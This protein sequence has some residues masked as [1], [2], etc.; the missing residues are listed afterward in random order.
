M[1]TRLKQSRMFS[2]LWPFTP[3]PAPPGL[4]MF[5]SPPPN[6]PVLVTGNSR[7]TLRKLEHWLAPMGARVLA[8]DTGGNDIYSALAAGALTINKIATALESLPMGSAPTSPEQ[9]PP[10]GPDSSFL[11]EP[12]PTESPIRAA[13]LPWAAWVALSPEPTSI[14]G[15]TLT[16]GPADACDLP[17]FLRGSGGDLPD[18]YKRRRFPLEDRL[19]LS[20]AHTLAFCL[21]AAAPLVI[22]G[23]KVLLIGWVMAVGSVLLLAFL[24]PWL[25]GK[26]GAVKGLALATVVLLTEMAVALL[27]PALWHL[28]TFL[29]AAVMALLGG[30]LG[31]VCAPILRPTSFDP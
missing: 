17:S 27:Q 22:F 8:V 25:P 26:Q 20:L 13:L 7:H 23:W 31:Q 24:W 4:H 18:S 2:G 19:E 3:D 14:P 12:P 9:K 5:G 30:W 16:P 29:F 28:N 6:A 11:Q 1:F 15:W 21:I 10:P